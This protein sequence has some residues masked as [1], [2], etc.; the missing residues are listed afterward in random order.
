MKK[1]YLYLMTMLAGVSMLFSS[2]SDDDD[3]LGNEEYNSER[4][5]MPQ[6]RRQQNT[7]ISDGADPYQCQIA[8][9]SQ[10]PTCASRYVNDIILYWYGVE[11]A[12]GYQIKAK[13][14]GTEWDR[15]EVLDTIVGA[16]TL[17]LLHEDLQYSVG[18]S[19]AIRALS[20]RGEAYHSKWYGYGD[21]SHQ[22][23]YMVIDTGNRY[24]VPELFWASN[25]EETTMRVYFDNT[26]SND[27]ETKYKDFIEAGGTIEDGKW[28][29]E[30][31]T[32]TPTAD[33]P[34]V[35]TKVHKMTET[36]WANGYVD[37][38]GL[39]PNAAYIVTGQNNGVTRF[40]DRQYNKVCPRMKGAI[41]EPILIQHIVEASDSM[42]RAPKAYNVKVQD[43][44]RIDTVLANYMN[45]TSLSEGTIFY[46]EGGKNY[47]FAQS[48]TLTKGFTLE[49]NPEDL[50]AGK[51]RANVYLGVGTSDEGGTSANN[52]T[53]MLSR[54]AKSG[55]ENGVFL[56]FQPMTFREINFGPEVY[57]NYWDVNGKDGDKTKA[58]SANYFLN[59]NS[60]GLS[61]SLSELN[62]ENCSFHGCNRGFIRFQGPNRQ[63]IEQLKVDGC[64]F[65]D[66][67]PYDNNG[68][69]YAWFAGPGNNANSNFYKN[70]I[71]RNSSFIDCPRHAFISENGNL[72]WPAGT[73]WNI[74]IEN[75][76]FV[77]LSPFSSSSGHGLLL[78]TRYAP[79]LSKITIKN[80]LFVMV[81]K[82]D[83]DKRNLYMRGMRISTKS[84]NYDIADNYATTV[85]N[86][87]TSNL[88]DG[89]WTNY[90]FSNTSDGAGYQSGILNAGGLSETRIKF[91][92]NRNNNEDDA[93]GYQLTP[94]ELFKDPAP[95][96]VNEMKDMLRHNVD[97]F[98]YKTDS[99]VQNHPIVTKKIGDQRWATGAPWK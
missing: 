33:N 35:E 4:L 40:Y 87:T 77:N 88:T 57:Y 2:C 7:G 64:V 84:I 17:Q 25:V 45:D 55:A 71:V 75:N 48:V 63:V 10:D 58:I 18:Y 9:N 86:W 91:G 50:A 24:A 54:N 41:G 96:A 67:G 69:G 62:I 59:M 3:K 80:N 49:T 44:C 31:I 12:V 43:L 99:K 81:R 8:A 61:F 51:G 38:D 90:A 26:A 52:V 85:P 74:T 37:F 98:Y 14:Q 82:G 19:Y 21:G 76:T 66:N 6:F 5:F 56:M 23:D 92:D 27:A 89:L 47:Y 39:T 30:E 16:E 46:L 29:F 94:E 13:V 68:R 65:Q 95:L 32:V 1:Y 72:A 36:D 93:V 28:V 60:Q 83:S 78:E 97:G 70:I 20:P 22:N 73:R 15:D 79:S 42:C 11:G 34:T 53:I